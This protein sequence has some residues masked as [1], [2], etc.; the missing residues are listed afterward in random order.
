LKCLIAKEQ[1]AKIG[2]TVTRLRVI[3]RANSG[4]ALICELVE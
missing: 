1:H 4:K 3:R 2:K